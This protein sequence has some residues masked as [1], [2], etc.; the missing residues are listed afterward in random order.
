MKNLLKGSLILGL[1][2]PVLFN[3][4]PVMAQ[5]S[6]T[7]PMGW[8]SYDCFN[9]T[10][11][12]SEVKANADY[13]AANLKEYG[14][15]YI[16]I[17]WAWYFTGTGTGSPNQDSSFNPKLNLDS[18]G[19]MIPDTTRFPSSANGQGFKPLADYIHGKGL[20]LGIHLM[21]GIPRQAVSANTPILGTSYRANDVADKVNLCAWLNLMYGL[22]MSHAGAQAYLNSLFELY[23]SWGIDFVKVDDLINPYGSPAYRQSEIEAYRTAINNCGREMVFSTSPGA[24][25]LANASHIMQYANQWRMANDLWDNWKNLN[26]MFDLAGQ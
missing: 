3:I 22:N 15:Q 13:M 26:A 14:W 2:V 19:R 5:V 17:D 4:L 11:T 1:A 7:P 24:T 10:A 21:R 8:N 23:A 18:Y 6:R 9:F 12:E 25:P 20:K 16:C